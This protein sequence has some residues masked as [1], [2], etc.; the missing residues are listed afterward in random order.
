MHLLAHAEIYPTY[1]QLDIYN[2]NVH[3]FLNIRK[4]GTIDTCIQF[5]KDINLLQ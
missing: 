2:E 5:W 1:T 4:R 3:S